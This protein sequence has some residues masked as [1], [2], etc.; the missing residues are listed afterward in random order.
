M[1]LPTKIV[2][3]VSPKNIRNVVF[4]F[5]IYCAHAIVALPV[6]YH[7][8]ITW[9]GLLL[10]AQRMYKIYIVET[11][12]IL[13]PW[14]WFSRLPLYLHAQIKKEK[15]TLG[16]IN[17]RQKEKK[18]SWAPPPSLSHNQV[19]SFSSRASRSLAVDVVH[20]DLLVVIHFNQP[21]LN[22]MSSQ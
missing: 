8:N 22:S 17:F 9:H 20:I 13:F 1:I 3:W 16:Q 7:V 5:L 21:L 12:R 2:L 11:K 6:V 10:D 4:V 15:D 18:E 14:M 19:S